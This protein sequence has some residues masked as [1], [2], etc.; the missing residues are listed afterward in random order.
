MDRDDFGPI[1]I[2]MKQTQESSD[3]KV[4]LVMVMGGYEHRGDRPHAWGSTWRTG[5]CDLWGTV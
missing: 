3:I 1:V 5:A 2:A 4:L